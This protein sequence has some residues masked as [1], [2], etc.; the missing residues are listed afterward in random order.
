MVLF[1]SFLIFSK[2]QIFTRTIS[3]FFYRLDFF[4]G[5]KWS[6]LSRSPKSATNSYRG[7]RLRSS[8]TFHFVAVAEVGDKYLSQSP[9][10]VAGCF[11]FCRGRRNRRQNLSRSPT[12]AAS[13]FPIRRGRRSRRQNSVAVA[14]FGLDRGD[15]GYGWDPFRLGRNHSPLR[16]EAERRTTTKVLAFSCE[17]S[18]A[19]VAC[20]TQCHRSI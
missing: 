16:F 10:L 4:T 2:V 19:F 6:K 15:S 8:V 5:K 11:E 18:D 12:S 13:N 3:Q 9:T 14:D 1:K 17:N 20:G 7:R